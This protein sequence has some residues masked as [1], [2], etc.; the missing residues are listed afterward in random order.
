MALE[1]S[2]TTPVGKISKKTALI[3]GGGLTAVLGIVWYRSKKTAAATNAQT[4]DTTNL[5]PSIYDTSTGQT[6][7]S[8][9]LGP[10]GQD[11]SA[12]MDS[13][14][15]TGGQVIGY[16]G[17]GQPIYGPAG[18]SFG[19]PTPNS[20]PGTFTSN[21]QWSQY[22]QSYLAD[23]VGLNASTVSEALG[24]YIEGRP[25]TDAEV[26]II[27]QAIA[28]AGVPPVSGTTGNPP[29]FNHVATGGTG[30]GTGT[31]AHNPV[32][33]L[34]IEG[35]TSTSFTVN[36]NASKGAKS[37]LVTVFK[38]STT[39]KKQTVTAPNSRLTVT[40]L[41]PGTSYR[42]R[43]RAQP[44]GTGG[45]DANISVRTDANRVTHGPIPVRPVRR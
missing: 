13:S 5:D 14:S 26:A 15:F 17:S 40:G 21:G 11:P 41:I 38:G 37:Y 27:S 45:R 32:N 9:G 12:Q 35:K 3:T 24:A 39:I 42:V 10:Y 1:G 16:D 30:G 22:A 4:T 31:V 36:W 34:K 6:W 18:G 19:T 20:G 25:V 8:E 23:T 43:V 2:V 33:G 29:G 28:F 44:G 7:A